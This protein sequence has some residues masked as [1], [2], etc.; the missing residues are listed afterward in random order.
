MRRS[1]LVL[2]TSA[3]LVLPIAA[4]TAEFPADKPVTIVV[5][6][7]AGGPTDR[8]VRDLAHSMG[9]ALHQTIV[10]ENVL[11]A[12]G[13]I[14]ARK[15]A[16]APKDGY[17]LL[18]HTTG[19][20]TASSLY[21]Q[22][23]YDPLRDFDYIGLIVDVPMVLLGSRH[24]APADLTAAV[25]YIGA[26]PGKV[27][28]GHAGPG[29]AAHL[30]TLL[31]EREIK[32]KLLS[33]AYKGSA[34]ALSDAIGGQI[35]LVCDQPTSSGGQIRSGV[36]KPYAVTSSRRLPSFPALRTSAEQGLSGFDVTSWHG[37]YA[38]RGIPEAARDRLV[39]A[40]R[41]AVADPEFRQKMA[42]L[43]GQVVPEAD[44]APDILQKKLESETR[45]WAAVIREAGLK[46]N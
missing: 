25:R 34:P 11:G 42:E 3:W 43:G 1:L 38:P 19:M 26:N 37:M 2:L 44:V 14:G 16:L 23:G 36:V 40:L 22:L 4:R 21:K 7:A 9:R 35:D 12:G 8:V 30:C 18:V 6:F 31:F 46:P 5:P 33:V 45:R 41:A 20:S 15:V 39:A 13:T 28:I 29:S 32:G 10:V 17:T 24:F 27:S